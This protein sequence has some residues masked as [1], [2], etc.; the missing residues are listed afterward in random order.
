[1]EQESHE[2]DPVDVIAVVADAADT[3]E[4]EDHWM[5]VVEADVELAMEEE[6]DDDD[7]VRGALASL[8]KMAVVVAAAAAAAAT[9][10]HDTDPYNFRPAN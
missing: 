3:M 10:E 9:K 1:M 6:E 2:E 4:Q 5:E 7:D 8:N